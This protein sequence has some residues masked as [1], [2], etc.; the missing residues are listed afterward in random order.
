MG[1]S[2]EFEGVRDDGPWNSPKPV[3]LGASPEF[4]AVRDA[5]PCVSPRFVLRVPEKDSGYEVVA[6]K[7]MGSMRQLAFFGPAQLLEIQK[8]FYGCSYVSSFI[9]LQHNMIHRSSSTIA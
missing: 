1:T 5:E 7:V 2:P 3:F 9:N 6:D 8:W 4:D